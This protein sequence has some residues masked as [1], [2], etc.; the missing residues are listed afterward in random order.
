LPGISEENLEWHYGVV[1]RR[2]THH[3]GNVSQS[4]NCE[5]ENEEGKPTAA[6]RNSNKIGVAGI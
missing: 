4:D 6:S 5:P 3:P 1:L 2:R